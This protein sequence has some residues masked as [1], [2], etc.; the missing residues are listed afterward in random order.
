M[1]KMAI[2]LNGQ[3]RETVYSR[4]NKACHNQNAQKY[5][6][7]LKYIARTLNK[8]LGKL[9]TEDLTRAWLFISELI[10]QDVFY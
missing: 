4:I 10:A 9:S 6:Q 2:F 3:N 1:W 5:K 7:F 8:F